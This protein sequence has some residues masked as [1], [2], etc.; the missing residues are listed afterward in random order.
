VHTD[1]GSAHTS[2]RRQFAA[3]LAPAPSVLTTMRASERIEGRVGGTRAVS[4]MRRQEGLRTRERRDRIEA[5]GAVRFGPAKAPRAA[6]AARADGPLRRVPGRGRAAFPRYPGERGF[7]FLRIAL[8]Q[9]QAT[10]GKW[11]TIR[12]GQAAHTNA[13]RQDR[14]VSYNYVQV[15]RW[16]HLRTPEATMGSWRRSS[17]PTKADACAS[18]RGLTSLLAE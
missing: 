14:H 10:A 2:V 15:R 4:Q 13:M 16:E 9:R 6:Y 11:D 8:V 5:G 18:R 3:P 12:G 7:R 1:K 17:E